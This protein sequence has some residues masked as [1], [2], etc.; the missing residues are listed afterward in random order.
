MRRRDGPWDD[1]RSG[2]ILPIPIGLPIGLIVLFLLVPTLTSG[3][4]PLMAV[5]V[6][7]WIAIAW[8]LN[9]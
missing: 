2:W 3:L 4:W 6:F 8:R 1:Q 9:R 5:L 7:M